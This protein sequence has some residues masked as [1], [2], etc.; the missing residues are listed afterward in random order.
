MTFGKKP[1]KPLRRTP[2]KRG[3]KPLR[4]VNPVATA[5][6]VARRRKQRNSPEEKAAR[7]LALDR[8]GGVCECGCGL[9]FDKSDGPQSPDYPEFH[10][11]SYDPPRGILVRRQCHHRIEKEKFP[12][13]HYTNRRYS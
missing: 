9:L 1:R 11:E 8:A 7:T 3:T 4:K 10:H 5:K 13:R 12:H 6:R 2:L